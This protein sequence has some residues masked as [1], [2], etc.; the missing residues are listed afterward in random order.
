MRVIS[1]NEP[2]I[3]LGGSEIN[4]APSNVLFLCTAVQGGAIIVTKRK[5]ISGCFGLL[6]VTLGYFGLFFGKFWLLLATFGYCLL[7]MSTLGYFWLFWL[8]LATFGFGFFL[9]FLGNFV[10][11]W[12]LLINFGSFLLLLGLLDTFW[13]N[14]GSFDKILLFLAGF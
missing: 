2:C 4:W 11:Y 6:W 7:T 3:A 10:Y 13:L 1:N 12:L 8:H 14:W 5:A 9:G